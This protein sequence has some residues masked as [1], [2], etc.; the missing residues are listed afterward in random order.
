MKTS[1]K[2]ESKGRI[3]ELIKLVTQEMGKKRVD[4]EV[5]AMACNCSILERQMDIMAESTKQ[6]QRLAAMR[7]IANLRRVGVVQFYEDMT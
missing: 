2:V 6:I 5:L 7:T 3:Y 4:G 1:E